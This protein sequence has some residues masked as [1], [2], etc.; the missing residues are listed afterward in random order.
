[1]NFL[2]SMYQWFKR[3]F[4]GG[5]PDVQPAPLP[6]PTPTPIPIPAPQPA[7]FPVDRIILI[8]LENTR[9]SKAIKEPFLKALAA[10][11]DALLLTKHTATVHPSQPNYLSI[12]FGDFF[13]HKSNSNIDL[14][15]GHLGDLL[16]SAGL[17]WKMYCE[18]YPGGNFTKSDKGQYCRK[19][20]PAISAKNVTGNPDRFARCVVGEE[21]FD[22]DLALGKLP[23]LSLYIP[24]NENN[25][26]ET[27][28]SFASK[29][30]EKR[31]GKLLGDAAFM[32]RSLVIVCFD[33]D[34]GDEDNHVYTCLVSGALAQ[35]PKV[36]Q[37]TT[38]YSLTRLIRETYGI[39]M[40]LTKND[41]TAP[42]LTGLWK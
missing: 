35:E 37:G 18:G 42:Q 24:D 22:K 30:L 29:Y 28:V 6:Q 33:E 12:W 36:V 5:N 11:K 26:H 9:Y 20:A 7:K 39:P 15:K 4:T 41:Q 38:H 21:Q 17:S 16:E 3:L 27:G 31:F 19:H 1:M 2:K 34:N 25:G 23:N 10:R 13:G 8:M 40:A 14:D 32:A